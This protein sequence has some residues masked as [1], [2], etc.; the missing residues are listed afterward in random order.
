MPS[1]TWTWPP[2]SQT[3]S[4]KDGSG[5]LPHIQNLQKAESYQKFHQTLMKRGYCNLHSG[6]TWQQWGLPRSI[7]IQPAIL[8]TGIHIRKDNVRER[9]KM[10]R[11]RQGWFIA[12]ACEAFPAGPFEG[13]TLEPPGMAPPASPGPG[14]GDGE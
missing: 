12:G 5:W 1:G 4:L 8:Y 3:L 9:M 11:K 14:A 10:R 7:Q 13:E 2:L 6:S